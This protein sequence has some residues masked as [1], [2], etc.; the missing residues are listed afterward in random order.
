V[1]RRAASRLEAVS[2]INDTFLVAEYR[3]TLL[4]HGEDQLNLSSSEVS[5]GLKFDF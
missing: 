3:N 4:V 2:G 1:D 5:F